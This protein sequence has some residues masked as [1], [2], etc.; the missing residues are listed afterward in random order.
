MLRVI[1]RYIHPPNLIPFGGRFYRHRHRPTN[2]QNLKSGNPHSSRRNPRNSE[3][4]LVK[5]KCASGQSNRLILK[6]SS[7]ESTSD[8]IF[9]DMDASSQWCGC[10]IAM[11]WVQHRNDMGAS[12]WWCGCIIAMIWVH[13][14]NDKGASLQWYRCVIAMMWLHHRNNMGKTWS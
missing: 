6:I 1:K 8:I 3:Y 10:V 7:A 2:W 4:N 12:S 9:I 11:I 5:I 13:H 14:R